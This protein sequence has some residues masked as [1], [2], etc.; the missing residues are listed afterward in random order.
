MSM[1]NMSP[2]SCL[3]NLVIPLELSEVTKEYPNGCV[4]NRS[5]SLKAKG[6]EVVG[7]IG[8]NGSGKTTLIRQILGLLPATQGSVT[9]LGH[10]MPWEADQIR[11]RVGY[12]PQMPM[13]YPSLTPLELVTA[14]IRMKGTRKRQAKAQAAHALSEVGVERD[15]AGRY[16]Y[17][18]SYGNLKLMNIAMALCQDPEL[19]VLDEPTSMVDIV[20]KAQVRRLLARQADRCVVLTSHDL[21]DIRELCTRAVVLVNG[22]IVAQGSPRE[23]ASQ[24]GDTVSLEV[25]PHDPATLESALGPLH[26]RLN[27]NGSTCTITARTLGDVSRAIALIHEKGVSCE[28]VRLD[29][30]S[31]ETGVLELI[32][33]AE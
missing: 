17:Q 30:P 13:R 27:W 32:K 12:V 20:N 26:C 5:I 21:S 19:L 29:A 18:L 33:G 14:I 15:V 2:V 10:R 16:S 6:G 4:A 28:S 3:D 22:R 8:P 7:V 24:I 31:L 9:V 11:G 23:L 1:P 25:T